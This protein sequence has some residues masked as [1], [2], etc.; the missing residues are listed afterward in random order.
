MKPLNVGRY[1]ILIMLILS[2]VGC[3]SAAKPKAKQ[4]MP[5]LVFADRYA[6]FIARYQYEQALAVS[7]PENAKLIKAE[8]RPFMQR[9][10]TL[11]GKKRLSFKEVHFLSAYLV[12]GDEGHLLVLEALIPSPVLKYGERVMLNYE[13]RKRGDGF[14]VVSSH[15][16]LDPNNEIMK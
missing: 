10:A 3:Q 14:E 5:A 13:V 1:F 2:L 15:V 12:D 11:N 6:L 4:E 9:L 16:R 8:I 7:T